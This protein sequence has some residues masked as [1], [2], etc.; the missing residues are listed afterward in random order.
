MN[1]IF[2]ALVLIGLASPAQAFFLTV[3][4]LS[5]NTPNAWLATLAIIAA[6]QIDLD[7]LEGSGSPD[8]NSR[9]YTFPGAPQFLG[10][11]DGLFLNGQFFPFDPQESTSLFGGFIIDIQNDAR[12][13]DGNI[14]ADAVSIAL[15]GGALFYEGFTVDSVT[16]RLIDD[17]ATMLD[18]S[19]LD[20]LFDVSVSDATSAT[21]T[22]LA[23]GT[24]PEFVIVNGTLD[25]FEV[26]PIPIPAGAWLMLSALSGLLGF[27]RSRN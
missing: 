6:A 4:G 21:F 18:S 3:S 16:F 1:K 5:D 25:T 15:N 14:V 12:D 13:N 7:A 23:R 19:S 26:R 8:D 11:D 24:P 22:V 9:E 17:T 20:E 27:S 10:P 2:L